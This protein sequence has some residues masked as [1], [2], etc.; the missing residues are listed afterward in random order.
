MSIFDEQIARKPD[1]YPFTAEFINAMWAGHWTPNEFTFRS[2]I[3]NFKTELSEQERQIITKTLSAIGQIEI[4]VK[5]FWAKVGDVLPHPSIVDMGLVMANIE[6]IHNRAYEKLLD[7]L[8]LNQAFEENLKLD[9]IVGRVKYLRKYLDKKYDNDKKQFI[10][11]L[12]LFTLFV[13][14]VSLFSQFYVI[15]WF[16]RY[17]NILKDTAQQV[18][19]TAKEECFIEGTEVLTPTGWIDFRNINIDDDVC[20]YNSNGTISFVKVL[21]KVENDFKGNLLQFSRKG[22]LCLVTP[23]HEMVYFDTNKEF[24]R[25]KAKDV[26][27]HKQLHVPVGAILNNG[28]SEGLSFED[29]LRIVIQADGTNLYWINSANEKLFRGKNGGATH[30]IGLTKERK[31]KRLRWILENLGIKYKEI[32]G[33][34]SKFIIYYN[35]DF[36]YKYFKWVDLKNKSSSWCKEFIEEVVEW[37]GYH[38]NEHIGYCST[39]KE[40]VDIVQ[41]IGIFAGY[42]TNIINGRESERKETYK[43]CFKLH[44]LKKNLIPKSHSLKKENIEYEGKVYCITVPSGVIITRYK[45]KTFIAGNC[46]HAQIGVKLVNTIRSEFPNLFDNDL[47]DKIYQES[48]EAFKA[49]S[50]IIDWILSGYEDEKI[51][52]DILKEYVKKRINDSL[53]QIEFDKVFELDN[54][55][56][57]KSDWMDEEVLGNTATDFFFKRPIEYQKKSQSFNVEDLF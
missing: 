19:Y 17:K 46:V 43:N 13:E 44:F 23:D 1:L 54:K 3:Q 18:Q 51:S 8:E 11:S 15:S 30:S 26:K 10:Y 20:Q 21:N 36:D 56:I 14:N 33:H 37:D 27:I 22:H 29:R 25:K 39:N 24:I 52:S 34:E 57:E 45:N 31:K 32:K 42:V 6:V 53:V 2:D 28:S 50:K 49:E 47:K 5:K 40:N 16:H 12:I 4:A 35:N 7:V 48:K 41:T 9:I 55:L 38:E